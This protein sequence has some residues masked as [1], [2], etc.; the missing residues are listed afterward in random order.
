[1][2]LPN[3]LWNAFFGFGRIGCCFGEGQPIYFL[4]KYSITAFRIASPLVIPWFRQCFSNRSSSFAS[5]QTLYLIVLGLSDLGLPV[6]GLIYSPPY[7]L[8]HQKYNIGVMKSQEEFLKKV[9]EITRNIV[10]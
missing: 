1:M 7:F 8:P 2:D 4:S 5:R 10:S 3:L 9:P 6:R